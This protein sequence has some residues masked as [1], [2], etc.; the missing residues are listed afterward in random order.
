MIK[1]IQYT[2]VVNTLCLRTIQK[3]FQDSWK[4]QNFNKSSLYEISAITVQNAITVLKH[5]LYQNSNS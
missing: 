4:E 1:C 5:R 2:V 3:F